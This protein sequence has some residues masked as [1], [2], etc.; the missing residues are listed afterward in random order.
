MK[1]CGFLSIRLLIPKIQIPENVDFRNGILISDTLDLK[2]DHSDLRR[3]YF[4]S[5]VSDLNEF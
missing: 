1:L 4:E 2:S 3:T 5:E